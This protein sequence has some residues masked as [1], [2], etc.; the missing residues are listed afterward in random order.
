MHSEYCNE[1]RNNIQESIIVK[2][3]CYYVND[4]MLQTMRESEQNISQLLELQFSKLQADF[5]ILSLWA[6]IL[7][8]VFLVFS[9]Y[10][11]FKTDELMKQSRDVLQH[12]DEASDKV[13]KDMEAISTQV[14]T[15]TEKATLELRQKTD[16]ELQKIKEEINKT[17]QGFKEVTEKKAKEYTMMYQSYLKELQKA[18]ESSQS[19]INLLISTIRSSDS[20]SKPG[21]SE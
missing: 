4:L 16:A 6:G 10:S 18:N 17:T 21:K 19:V 13:K 7:M 5:T 2:D 3:S 1:L 8:I 9:I 20:D 14:Q 15:E 11:V 12:A